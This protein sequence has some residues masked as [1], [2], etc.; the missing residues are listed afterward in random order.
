M[1]QQLTIKQAAEKMSLTV[2]TLRYYEEIGIL[3]GIQRNGSGHRV[4]DEQDL[5]W[6]SWIKLLRSS[7]M[8]IET[9]R[10]FVQLTRSGNDSIPA[11]CEILDAHRQK[12]RNR[13][14]ELQG[15]LA[16]LDDKLQFYRGLEAEL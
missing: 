3:P 7:G 10:E 12:I 14:E 6:I 5:G 8:P 9:I 4:Y 15:F 16:K 1:E 2:Y 13:I 11:R